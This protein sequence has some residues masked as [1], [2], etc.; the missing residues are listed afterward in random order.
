MVRQ[1]ISYAKAHH[2]WGQSLS[3]IISLRLLGKSSGQHGLQRFGRRGSHRDRSIRI[4]LV[5]EPANAVRM[6]SDTLI[7]AGIAGLKVS[8]S[9]TYLRIDAF[10]HELKTNA[11]GRQGGYP[12]AA[13]RIGRKDSTQ[14]IQ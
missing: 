7:L 10:E 11:T 4:M 12:R 5:V 9:Y 6:I 14:G 8:T 13:H 2:F 3:M 1:F